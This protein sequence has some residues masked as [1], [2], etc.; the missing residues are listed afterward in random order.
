[1]ENDLDRVCAWCKKDMGKKESAE[2]GTT[3]G[4]CEECLEKM[5]M[6]PVA[7]VKSMEEKAA[8]GRAMFGSIQNKNEDKR[9]QDFNGPYCD[10]HIKADHLWMSGIMFGDDKGAHKCKTC[11]KTATSW[12]I[13]DR[14]EMKG[15]NARTEEEEAISW[16]KARK[17]NFATAE[18][19]EKAAVSDPGF[20]PDVAKKA[21]KYVMEN[22]APGRTL[23]EKAEAGRALFGSVKNEG[24]P[25]L[26][27]TVSFPYYGKTA[28]IK[29]VDGNYIEAG[30]IGM[31]ADRVEP[32]GPG[33]WIYKGTVEGGM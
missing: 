11:G 22:A 16:I 30:D 10:E 33:R 31:S 3:H 5:K 17:Q 26:G 28:K 20:T 24:R 4:I 12:G 8:D 13:L 7:N 23:E 32:D 15:K 18:E 21:A 29:I 6:K 2:T 25:K 1:M 27:D 14:G 19:A 9:P